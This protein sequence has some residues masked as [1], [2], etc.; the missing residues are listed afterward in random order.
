MQ[1]KSG[2][3]HFNKEGDLVTIRNF[4]NNVEAS[5]ELLFSFKEP[6]C[7]KRAFRNKRYLADSKTQRPYQRRES[8]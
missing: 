3:L 7:I 1:I 8:V 4:D 2:R 5:K 6:Y